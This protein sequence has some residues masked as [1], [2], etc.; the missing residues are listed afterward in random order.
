[1]DTSAI[2]IRSACL[3]D[4]PRLLE[5]YDHYV[6]HTAISFEY[7]TPSRAEFEG[8][9]Q[10]FMRRYP[11][12][13]ALRNG[14]IEGYAYA[15]PFIDR[16]AYDWACEL[17]IYL[18]KNAQKCGMGRRLYEAL[19]SRLR[20]M[21]VVDLYACIAC[22]QGDDPYLS[23]NSYDFHSHLGFRQVGLFPQMRLQIWPLVRYGVDG[24]KHRRSQRHA[25]AGSLAE[26]P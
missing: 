17:T 5:I 4:A 26:R 11:Y 15:H 3:S 14:R 22:P 6:K 10:A 2:T 21:G 7:V 1:M 16:A 24:Q 12:L 19:E 13:V 9:M 8:R 18:D 25:A 23:A 20:E